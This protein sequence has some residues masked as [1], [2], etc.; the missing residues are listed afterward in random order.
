MNRGQGHLSVLIVT[1]CKPQLIRIPLSTEFV[2]PYLILNSILLLHA[3]VIC[4]GT[5]NHY[6][7]LTR[8][9]EKDTLTL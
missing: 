1:A 3:L 9:H 8:F 4:N 5:W 6:I 7:F 2:L